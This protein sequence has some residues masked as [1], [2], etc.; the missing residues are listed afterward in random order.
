[1]SSVSYSVPNNTTSPFHIL[2]AHTS[3]QRKHS[4][5]LVVMYSVCKQRG[6]GGGERRKQQIRRELGGRDGGNVQT[7]HGVKRDKMR[8]QMFGATSRFEYAKESHWMPRI[9]PDAIVFSGVFIPFSDKGT[10]ERV[11]CALSLWWQ[12]V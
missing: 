9:N 6:E 11:P 4:F 10:R 2:L 3:K 5:E 7:P 8:V 12:F 1:M